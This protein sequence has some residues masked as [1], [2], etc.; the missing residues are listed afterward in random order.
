MR[1]VL[2]WIR[3]QRSL[4]ATARKDQAIEH[5]GKP[6]PKGGHA[7]DIVQKSR[8]GGGPEFKVGA[9]AT[10]AEPEI[11]PGIVAHELQTDAH[12]LTVPLGL[13]GALEIIWEGRS[14]E[15][16]KAC[17][18]HWML[19]GI[20]G[21]A[22]VRVEEQELS[23]DTIVAYGPGQD[24][25]QQYHPGQ[26]EGAERTAQRHTPAGLPEKPQI[27]YGRPGQEGLAQQSSHN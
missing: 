15:L 26:D 12:Q 4:G 14:S 3:V 16:A 17:A 2:V 19:G 21:I 18:M 1:R 6:E 13:V 5:E 24:A 7:P 23:I 8:I 22:G 20:H 27:E 25:Q 10:G 9:S 11:A